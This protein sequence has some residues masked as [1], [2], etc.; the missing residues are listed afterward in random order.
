MFRRLR[1]GLLFAFLVLQCF[2][3]AK[4]IS[5]QPPGPE[6]FIVRH[7]PPP[8]VAQLLRVACYDCHSNNTRYPWYAELQPVG[9]WLERHVA[10]GKDELNLSELGG[11]GDK[12]QARRIEA[13]L[14]VISDGSMPLPSYLIIHRDA[15]LTPAQVKTLTD[16]LQSVLSKVDPEA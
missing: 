16:W 2:R 8:E 6:D 9:I 12:R 5:A 1:L 15:R 11:A 7:A 10:E 3:P 13:M 14:D 4:N